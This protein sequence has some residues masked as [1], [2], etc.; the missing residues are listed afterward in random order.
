M[1][2]VLRKVFKNLPGS[3]KAVTIINSTSK[4][5]ITQLKMMQNKSIQ[6]TGFKI[7][8]NIAINLLKNINHLTSIE[9]ISDKARVITI[10]V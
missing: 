8:Q 5:S 6:I 7:W 4:S 10:F 2:E 1:K 3:L 9:S